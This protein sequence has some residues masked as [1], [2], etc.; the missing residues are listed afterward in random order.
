MPKT[1]RN[2]LQEAR[3]QFERSVDRLKDYKVCPSCRH[4]QP[5]GDGDYVC[6]GFTGCAPIVLKKY[7]PTG[8]YAGCGG[9]MWERR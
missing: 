8:L 1:K 5:V 3:E 9:K 4:C 6:R 7:K 2:P